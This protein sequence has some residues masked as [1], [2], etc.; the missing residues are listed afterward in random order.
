MQTVILIILVM[1]LNHLDKTVMQPCK[2][3]HIKGVDKDLPRWLLAA[4]NRCKD[5]LPRS[6]AEMIRD[7]NDDKNDIF[8]FRFRSE[9]ANK[10]NTSARRQWM[11]QLPR[12]TDTDPEDADESLLSTSLKYSFLGLILR[13]LLAGVHT[14]DVENILCL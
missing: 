6:V 2:R 12:F 14:S 1:P 7:Q 5:V 10:F 3:V 4:A 11:Q 9:E 13:Q 8:E